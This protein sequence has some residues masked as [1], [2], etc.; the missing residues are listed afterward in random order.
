MKL[1]ELLEQPQTKVQRDRII[2]VCNHT[3][4]V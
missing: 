3:T 1:V 2:Q 4:Q